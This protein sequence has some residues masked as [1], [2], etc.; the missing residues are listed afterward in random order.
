MLGGGLG[1]FEDAFEFFI[2]YVFV[3]PFGDLVVFE[4]EAEIL[5]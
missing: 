5:P 4:F 2:V 1:A 3:G